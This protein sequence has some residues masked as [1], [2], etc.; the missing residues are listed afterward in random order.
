MINPDNMP[1]PESE[2]IPPVR[3]HETENYITAIIGGGNTD[4]EKETGNVFS[5]FLDMLPTAQNDPLMK[6]QLLDV[7]KESPSAAELIIAALDSEEFVSYH[8]ELIAMCWEAAI[9]MTAHLDYFVRLAAESSNPFILLEIQTVI[10][11]MDLSDAVKRKAAIEILVASLA[12]KEDEV[13]REI[14]NDIV[15]FLESRD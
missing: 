6:E 2:N 14:A 12:S 9:D 11:D 1:E 3:I 15:A 5:G 7:L 8:K 10:Q 13:S 4:P